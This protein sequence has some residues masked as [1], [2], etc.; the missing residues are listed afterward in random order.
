MVM[1]TGQMEVNA[2]DFKA[3][4]LALIDRAHATGEVITITKRG[5]V[6]ARLVGAA[7]DDQRPWHSLRDHPARWH[8]D[9]LAPVLPAHEIEAL[10]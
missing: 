1:Y 4:C 3:R 2:T 9:P 6:V 5:R 7:Q 8:G 10:K